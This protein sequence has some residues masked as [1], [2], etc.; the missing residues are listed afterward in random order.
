MDAM[1]VAAADAADHDS[2]GNLMMKMMRVVMLLIIIAVMVVNLLML[3]TMSMITR[4]VMVAVINAAS[5]DS[6]DNVNRY[7]DA[8][9]GDDSLMMVAM[10]KL[11][12]MKLK[13]IDE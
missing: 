6:D 13:A 8:H 1:N 9:D 7:A 4:T 12:R 3:V 5:A 10:M 2:V 11:N